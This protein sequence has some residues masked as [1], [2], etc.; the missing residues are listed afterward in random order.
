MNKWKVIIEGVEDEIDVQQDIY[1][2]AHKYGAISYSV[3][4]GRDLASISFSSENEAKD[5]RF[6]YENDRPISGVITEIKAPVRRPLTR[7][8]RKRV[9][10]KSIR[11]QG[12]LE[13]SEMSEDEAVRWTDPSGPS[14][15]FNGPSSVADSQ[16]TSCDGAY[17]SEFLK[18]ETCPA[19]GTET[20]VYMDD[21]M[22]GRSAAAE[23]GPGSAGW[24]DTVVMNAEGK[25][26][27]KKESFD[28]FVLQIAEQVLSDHKPTKNVQ[29]NSK[30]E[31]QAVELD[32]SKFGGR[33]RSQGR[34]SDG[35]FVVVIKFE[36]Y[37]SA[38]A[39]QDRHSGD[40]EIY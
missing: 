3:S 17:Y 21:G 29:L 39:F 19:C 12:E 24:K 20:I 2:L 34:H 18:G 22:R 13:M 15:N 33:V 35:K 23:F 16:C 32:A 9:S 6:I 11:E 28:K 25:I 4:E 38:D 37:E 36:D 31:L 8:K 30:E 7:A 1:A 27:I 5:F 26:R 40:W 10:R 14:D